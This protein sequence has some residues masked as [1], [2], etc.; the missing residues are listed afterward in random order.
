MGF[1]FGLI[2]ERRIAGGGEHLDGLVVNPDRR[3]VLAIM[4]SLAK[5]RV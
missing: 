5:D 2:L 4:C 1:K 3:G